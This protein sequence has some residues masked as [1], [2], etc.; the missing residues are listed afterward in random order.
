MTKPSSTVLENPGRRRLLGNGIATTGGVLGILGTSESLAG[1]ARQHWDREFDVIVVGCGLAGASAAY[2]AARSGAVVLVLDS[3]GAAANASHGTIIYMGGGTGLQKAC[4]IEDTPEAMM[5]YLLASTGPDPDTGRIRVF[6]ERSVANY[7]WLVSLGVPFSNAPDNLSLEYSG[8]EKV[9]PWRE[10]IRPV[11]RGHIPDVPGSKSLYRGGGAWIQKRLL[12][13]ARSAGAATPL[14][15]VARRIVRGH[16]GVVQGVVATIDGRSFSFRARRGLIL[17]T[18]GF[19]HNKE[20]VSEHAPIYLG[21][22]PTDLKWNDGWGIRAAQ[23]VGAAVRRMGSAGAGWYFYHPA[24]RR[25]GVLVNAQGQRFISEDSYSGRVGDAI[26]R[27]QHGIAYL[28]VDRTIM[29]DGA[30]TVI[31]DAIAAQAASIAD[32]EG[33]L[34]IPAPAL[35]QTLDTYNTYATKGQDP[36]FHKALEHLRPLS[37]GPFTAINASVGKSRVSFFTLGGVHTTPGAEVLDTEGKTIP[38]LYA[39]GRVSAGIPC[40]Y[41]YSSG[42]NLGECITF[43]RIAGIGAARN[44]T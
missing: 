37:Q 6:V 35:Q 17:A 36:L 23:S 44:R 3:G 2:E 14:N 42:L 16:D 13:G 18:G 32:L 21:C 33:L 27:E 4:Q 29:D 15:A 19:A 12:D 34:G 25:Q 22:T 8:S 1:E 31:P 26:V 39:V 40:P 30:S 41:Y 10:M 11:P 24:S 5:K 7:D 38:K 20:M 9:Y 43:G 28:I